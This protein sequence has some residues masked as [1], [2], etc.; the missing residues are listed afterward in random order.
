MKR[1]S[2]ICIEFLNKV[3]NTVTLLLSNKYVLSSKGVQSK[4]T[5]YNIEIGTQHPIENDKVQ[6]WNR[7]PTSSVLIF[8]TSLVPTVVS[9][10][11]K[12]RVPSAENN[13][14]LAIWILIKHRL[15]SITSVCNRKNKRSQTG[16]KTKITICFDSE[17]ISPSKL[18]YFLFYDP[19]A[20]IITR[21]HDFKILLTIL[22]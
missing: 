5:R 18:V 6:H 3:V 9:Y 16:L 10:K 21:C 14:D 20:R 12:C 8:V 11:A 7:N 15:S 17:W 13:T 1:I 2:W 19:S 4:T 22:L